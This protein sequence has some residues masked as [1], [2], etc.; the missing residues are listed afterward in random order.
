MSQNFCNHG[1]R[2][3]MQKSFFTIWIMIHFMNLLILPVY[4]CIKFY[5]STTGNLKIN[6]C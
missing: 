6:T 1:D 4:V 2:N 3:T 5:H